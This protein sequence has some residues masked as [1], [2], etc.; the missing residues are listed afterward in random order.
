MAL[1]FYVIDRHGPS[2]KIKTDVSPVTAKQDYK[3][4]LYYPFNIC[5]LI[6]ENRT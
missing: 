5:D 6:C 3:V 2:N 1:A 4:T